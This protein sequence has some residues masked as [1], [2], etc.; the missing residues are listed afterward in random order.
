MKKIICTMLSAAMLMSGA[1]VANAEKKFSDLDTVEWAAPYIEEMAEMGFITGYS[2]GTFKPNNDVTHLEGLVLF[3]R[4]MGSNSEAMSK[5]LEYA[6]EQYG[7]V[8]DEYNLNFGKDE[9]CFMLYRGALTVDELYEYIAP[10]IKDTPMKRHEAAVVIT[11]AM[12]GEKD[13][14]A[15]MILDLTYEDAK[16][17][18]AKATRYVY[19]ATEHGIMNGMDGNRFAPNNNIKRSQ[20]AVMLSRAVDA[21]GI[22]FFETMLEEVDTENGTVVTEDG[23]YEY[24]SNTIMYKEGEKQDAS[25]MPEN[26]LAL[27]TVI[28]DKLTF[29]DALASEPDQVVEGVFYDYFS[30]NDV[31][32]IQLRAPG[33]TKDEYYECAKGVRVSRNGETSSII[34]FKKGDFVTLNLSNGKVVSISA[35]QQTTVIEDAIISDITLA[36][37]LIVKIEHEDAEYNGMTLNIANDVSVKKNGATADLSKIYRGDKVNLTLDYG[38]VTKISATSSK[39]T[40]EGTIKAIHI[41]TNPY[42]IVAING[43]EK[44]YDISSSIDIKVNGEKGSIYDFRLN[45]TVKITIE[46]EAITAISATSVQSGAYSITAGTITAINPSYGFIKVSYDDAGVSKEETIMCKDTTTTVLN[47]A[48]KDASIKDLA[49]GDIVTV[50]G[51]VDNGAFV[52][53]V[54]LIESK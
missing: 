52:A 15:E 28:S 25:S 21:M 48:G 23:V 14:K 39:R 53:S 1:V 31:L 17:I 29:V 24:S 49:V 5:I 6:V 19:Y 32:N 20:I 11:K 4:A 2:D 51:T 47:A 16:D 18:P 9:I 45:D 35:K 30:K 54:I 33:T 26:V 8:V 44:T 37:D 27:L 42:M 3:S 50:R 41:A 34:D 43:N 22:S 46:S 40:L 13:A 7:A 12:A 10:E 38:Q 36:D